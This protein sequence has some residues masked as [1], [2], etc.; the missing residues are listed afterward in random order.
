MNFAIRALRSG[1]P[2]SFAERAAWLHHWSGVL[3][4]RWDVEVLHK[5]TLPK[6]G[7]IASNHLS[8]MDILVFA[9][10]GP[11]V[12]VSK[13]DVRG[14]PVI[15]WL[16]SAAGTIFVKRTTAK[17]V[18]QANERIEQA[19]MDGA[20]VVIFPEGTSSDGSTVLPFRSPLF[21]SAIHSGAALFP[22]I[23]RPCSPSW[24]LARLSPITTTM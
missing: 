22:A 1:H 14:W 8:Y 11:C 12:F 16:A 21:E 15:G 13:S 2:L 24:A 17:D 4:R 7:I 10:L 6:N 5:G 9:A 3:L 19:L 18:C 20:T 23:A